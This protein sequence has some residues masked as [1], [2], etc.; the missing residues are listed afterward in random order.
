MRILLVLDSFSGGGAEVGV[1]G[2]A[3][4]LAS[5]G[6]TIEIAYFNEG[7]L[8]RRYEGLGVPLHR[9][10]WANLR[11][12]LSLPRLMRI[13]RRFRPDIVHTHMA[14]SDGIGLVASWLL[15]VPVR[16]STLHGASAWRVRFLPSLASRLVVHCAH[17]VIP[18]SVAVGD[19]ACRLSGLPRSKMV[20]IPNAVD[21]SRFPVD[22]ATKRPSPPIVGM[23]GRLN[24][25]KGH[26]TFLSSAAI[27][28]AA[29]PDVRFEIVGEGELHDALVE[30]CRALG[31]TECVRFTGFTDDI[32]GV[33]RRF[34][35]LA[36]PS[37]H[38]GLPRVL[39][40]GMA[41]QLPIV[42]TAVDG[43]PDAITHGEQGVLIPPDD[44]PALADAVLGLL[45]DLE[46]AVTL[47]RNAR[48]RVAR[49]FDPGEANRRTVDLYRQ[50]LKKR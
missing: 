10:S 11:D 34:S 3:E 24:A 25:V 33:M 41:A 9:I 1:F 8:R 32:P 17:C 44:P 13:I 26:D 37:R 42:A 2:L 48:Q 38:E 16:L 5:D 18:V 46:R 43:I 35:V 36:M 47:G 27:I 23:V 20:V 4:A 14:K 21:V 12:P 31:L 15:R 22:A 49:E 19:H 50:L 30:R 40:E 29:R 7:R 39:L 6:H 45:N 28:H